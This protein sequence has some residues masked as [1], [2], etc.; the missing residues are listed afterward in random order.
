M[1][2]SSPS[3]TVPPPPPL[4]AASF[5][6][7]SSIF[8]LRELLLDVVELLV[9]ALVARL[10]VALELRGLPGHPRV[11]AERLDLGLELVALVD[12][13]VVGA[14]DL[15]ELRLGR[16]QRLARRLG[17][18][19]AGVA[20]GLE[21]RHLLLVLVAV[22]GVAQHLR[23][24]R[25]DLHLRV[26][27]VGHLRLGVLELLLQILLLGLEREHLAGEPGDVV[28]PFGRLGLELLDLVLHR[29]GGAELLL[30]GGRRLLRPADLGE[31]GARLGQLLHQ[32]AAL[33]A[34]LRQLRVLLLQ[35]V[36]ELLLLAGGGV[37]GLLQLLHLLLRGGDL[38]VPALQLGLVLV[39]ALGEHLDQVVLLLELPG[40]GLALGA[41]DGDPVLQLLQLPLQRLGLAP[42]VG[43]DRRLHALALALQLRR[44]VVGLLL[45]QLLLELLHLLFALL[46]EPADLLGV[47]AGAGGGVVG[48]LL[49]HLLHLRLELA[50][51]LLE[52]GDLAAQGGNLDLVLRL[53]LG[54]QA[55][56]RRAA[57]RVGD[58]AGR[59]LLFGF[60]GLL[61]RRRGR[62]AAGGRARGRL[63]SPLRRPARRGGRGA[64]R[65]GPR[66]RL[67][68]D[69]RRLGHAEGDH[70]AVGQLL[71]I[72]VLV[73]D[74][75]AVGGPEVHQVVLAVLAPDLR[76]LGGDACVADLDVAGG[77][78]AHGHR[79]GGEFDLLVLQGSA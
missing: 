13:V 10:P 40:D 68:A 12:D 71:A 64:R 51:L 22:A 72:D 46:E 3:S 28:L 41:A 52:E 74:E 33:L 5:A 43:L 11:G 42:A 50:V 37:G 78:A 21:H 38:L 59:R 27:G 26:E 18:L 61:R 58:D 47:G 76:V 67:V 34:E 44:R 57:G 31:D 1:S 66:L 48:G 8:H 2:L 63:R 73:V 49:F 56:L 65:I 24:L 45:V 7:W 54:A 36:V 15:R 29:L 55:G 14:A 70:V 39:L 20:V 53:H 23:E 32:V 79:V 69:E 4:A 25:V 17:L 19:G 9:G 60:G 6:C 16:R 62:A 30:D 35:L 77:R 75:G